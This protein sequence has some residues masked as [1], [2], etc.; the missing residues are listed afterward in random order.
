LNNNQL[1]YR[2]L[3]VLDEIDYAVKIG[4]L[5]TPSIAINGK[6]IFSSLPKIKDL[7]SALEKELT[8]TQ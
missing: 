8:N 7:I 2:E 4:V 6:L 3:D 1:S 5:K